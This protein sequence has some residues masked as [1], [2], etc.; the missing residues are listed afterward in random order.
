MP[1]PN[2]SPSPRLHGAW[3]CLLLALLITITWLALTPHPP[4]SA[5]LG[6]DKLN[7]L[8]AFGSLAFCA[9]RGFA[10]AGPWRVAAALLLYGALIEVAQSQVPGR[11]A[12]WGD[13][14]ADSLGIALGV[15]AHALAARW[16][17]LR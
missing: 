11:S 1:V 5:D 9:M 3:R 6:W 15:A 14:L 8:A 17:R 13:L 2:T 16:L 12:E 7:H 10:R 4:R